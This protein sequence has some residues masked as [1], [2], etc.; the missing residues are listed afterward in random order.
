MTTHKVWNTYHLDIQK[1]II[2]KVKNN[3][4][5]DDLLQDTFLKIHTKLHTLKEDR[6]LKSWCFSIARNSILN[7]WRA[8]NK[9]VEIAS[10]ESE[11]TSEINTN[12][13]T[14][15][16]CLRKILGN[17]PKKYRTPL[18]LSDIKG[19]KQQEVADQLNQT[20]STTKSQIQRAR[21]L[22]AQGFMDCCGFV[23]NEDGNLV[24]EIQ[25]KED[26]KVCN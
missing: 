26:C 23:M 12:K 1:F 8:N 20:L 9:T 2:S 18:F 11:T 3:T 5:A 10:F 6:K 17:L 14:E 22:I 7:Y 16:D 24:G 4:I 21:K 25:D 15:E 19:L 13:H